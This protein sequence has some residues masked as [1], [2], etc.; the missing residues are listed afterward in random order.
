MSTGIEGTIENII[1]LIK[2]RTYTCVSADLHSIVYQASGKGVKPIVVPMRTDHLFFKE[3]FVADTIIGKAAALL[4]ALSGAR[5]VY[6][7]I[8]SQAAIPVFKSNGII[9]EYGQLV[10]YI[11]NRDETGMCPLEECIQDETDPVTAWTEI[12]NKISEL[13]SFKK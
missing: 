8:M 1:Q 10:E 4:L 7:E 11:K 9:Y 6:G 3:K 2:S 12:E 5:Y 13:M